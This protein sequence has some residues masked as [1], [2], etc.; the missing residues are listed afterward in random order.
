MSYLNESLSTGETIRREAKLH[1]IIYFKGL[2]VFAIGLVISFV[3]Y[4]RVSSTEADVSGLFIS[5]PPLPGLVMIFLAF[6][7]KWT[8]DLAV[9]NKKVV[10]KVGLISRH[11]IEQNLISLDN[12]KVNQSV[13]GRILDF[14]VIEFAGASGTHTPIAY[15]AA[16]MKFRVA[17]QQAAEL[18]RE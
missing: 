12:V 16:P 14:G 2:V 18:A 5:I 7:R 13:L 17:V 6:L 15:I 3:I 8:T 11:T 10:A 4:Q 1:W 9:T